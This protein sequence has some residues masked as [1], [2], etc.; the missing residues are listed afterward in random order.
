MVLAGRERSMESDSILI[1]MSH[2]QSR[3]LLEE[4]PR[5]IVHMLQQVYRLFCAGKSVHVLNVVLRADKVVLFS[6]RS[7]VLEHH[8]EVILID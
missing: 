6:L 8:E 1:G 7:D 3:I 4:V 5:D 2:I